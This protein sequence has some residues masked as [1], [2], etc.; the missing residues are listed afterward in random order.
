[1]NISVDWQLVFSAAGLGLAALATILALASHR[2]INSAR[3][4]LLLLQGT[5]DGKTLIDAVAA[6][7]K[8]VRLL[9]DDIATLAKRQ[10]ALLGALSSS[11]RNIGLVRY[12]AF[13]DMGGSMSFSAA[14]LDDRGDGLILTSINGR[15]EARTYAKVVES[16]RSDN[17][18]SPE[19][20]RA[21]AEAMGERA[22]ARRWR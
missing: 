15:T 19:E 4:S 21:I 6:Y 1:M 20:E 8:E 22:K 3:R 11:A 14:L 2:R 10:E 9:S 18:L 17:N 12:D 7:I 16:G 13:E 5:H